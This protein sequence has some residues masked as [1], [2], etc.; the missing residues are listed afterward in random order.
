MEKQFNMNSITDG[1][2]EAYT[3]LSPITQGA[4]VL[5]L[6]VIPD[7]VSRGGFWYGVALA[8][9]PR[10]KMTYDS[11]YGKLGLVIL[12]FVLIWLDQRRLAQKRPK[13]YDSRTLKGR[14]LQLRDEIKAFYDSAPSPP[15]PQADGEAKDVYLKR[16]FAADSRRF[17]YLVHGFSWRFHDR[18]MVINCQFGERGLMDQKL[19]DALLQTM[20]KEDLYEEILSGLT[21]LSQY[22]E[23]ETGISNSAYNVMSF[24][25]YREGRNSG[26]F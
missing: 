5:L 7:W 25:E 22:P 21:R 16:M 14:T 13:M 12:A 15:P 11:P 10:L 9:W 3:R 1:V 18:A 8:A 2:K 4:L 24:E 20:K 19:N 17:D 23:K 6:I 26:A